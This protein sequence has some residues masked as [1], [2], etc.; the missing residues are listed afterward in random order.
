MVRCDGKSLGF[1]IGDMLPERRFAVGTDGEL[2]GRLEFAERYRRFWL[3]QAANEEPS[4][5]AIPN[6]V[7]FVSAT[8][9]QDG[10][11][12]PI[13]WDSDNDRPR[14]PAVKGHGGILTPEQIEARAAIDS[15]HI[16]TEVIKR[17]VRDGILSAEAGMEQIL[18]IG[19]TKHEH[20][21]DTTDAIQEIVKWNTDADENAVTAGDLSPRERQ[22]LSLAGDGVVTKEKIEEISD[23]TGL[24]RNTVRAY[25]GNARAKMKAGRSEDSEA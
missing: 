5:V 10:R 2:I 22:I 6:I 8:H 17:L 12:V 23:R 4:L 15:G 18:R 25:L 20:A 21:Q 11:M 3:A 13:G 7:E 1:T 19:Q 14:E 9:D 24:S 16:E